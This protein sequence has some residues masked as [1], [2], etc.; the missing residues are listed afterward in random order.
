MDRLYWRR[1][2]DLAVG[3]QVSN[4][5]NLK[6]KSH[7]PQRAQ[8]TQRGRSTSKSAS[9]RARRDRGAE[10]RQLLAVEI[11]LCLACPLCLTRFRH[12]LLRAGS[13]LG[14]GDDGHPSLSPFTFHLSPFNFQL[15]TFSCSSRSTFSAIAL[16][17][18]HRPSRLLFSKRHVE[19]FDQQR[20]RHRKVD[21]TLRQM[22]IQS[23]GDQRHSNQNQERQCEHLH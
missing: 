16:L 14:G 8:S 20:K 15:S 19:H 10:Q 3:A 11:P 2:P 18:R 6:S 13:R 12:S 17:L 4:G 7:Q 1:R 23:L 9:R 5:G 22:P 21:V